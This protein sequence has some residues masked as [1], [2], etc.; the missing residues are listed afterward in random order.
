MIENQEEEQKM[1]K[2]RSIIPIY[3]CTTTNTAKKKAYA[4][5][6]KL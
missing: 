4:L 2:I 6:S 3:Y 5:A 1:V